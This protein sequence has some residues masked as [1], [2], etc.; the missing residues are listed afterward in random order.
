MH[1]NT[2]VRSILKVNLLDTATLTNRRNQIFPLENR[3]R[4]HAHGGPGRGFV[5]LKAKCC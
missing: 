1:M 3:A 5:P 2:R 4:E